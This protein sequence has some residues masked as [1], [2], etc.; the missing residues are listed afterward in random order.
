MRLSFKQLR[1]P[2]KTSSR[3][4]RRLYVEDDRPWPVEFGG[5]NDSAVLASLMFNA[6]LVHS[7][8]VLPVTQPILVGQTSSLRWRSKENQRATLR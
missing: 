6:I 3:S 1:L 2:T 5:G 8:N 4:L 7:C